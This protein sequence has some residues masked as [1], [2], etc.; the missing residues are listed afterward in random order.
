M[1]NEKTMNEIKT[2]A[3]KIWLAGLG[4]VAMAEEGGEKLFK[5]LVERGEGLE[6][7]GK[8]QV[9]QLKE[10]VTDATSKGKDALGKVGSSFDDTVAGAL[11]RLGV[12][13]RD[14]IATLTKRVEELTASVERLAEAKVAQ[15]G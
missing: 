13:T 3:H 8:E 10:K 6:T 12:P 5:N 11:T 9:D 1:D 15:V 14:E 4:A 7:R 2:S